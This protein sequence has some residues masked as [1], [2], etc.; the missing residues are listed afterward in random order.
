M[1]ENRFG[2]I[3]QNGACRVEGICRSLAAN[4]WVE[5]LA[6]LGYAAKGLVYLLVGALAGLAAWQVEGRPIGTRGALRTI[7]AQ[8]F[9]RY[10][11]ATVAVGIV[12]FILRRFLQTLVEEEGTAETAEEHQRRRKRVVQIARRIGYAMSGIFHIGIALTTVRLLLGWGVRGTDGTRE[13][14][15]WTSFLLAQPFGVWLVALA[16][17]IVIGVGVGQLYLS[18]TGN[19]RRDLKWAEMTRKPRQWALY[20]GR[21]GYAARGLVLLIVGGFLVQAAWTTDPR[22]ARGLGAALEALEG[23]PFGAWILAAVAAGLFAYGVYMMVAARY[24]R[25]LAADFADSTDTPH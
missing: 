13:V 24:L 22:Q 25:L 4:R 7:V 9:G 3:A 6:K 17:L 19:F 2:A 14:Q 20:S 15:D 8:P 5:R 16:G 23:Q 10:L 21:V 12:G 18:Y 11:M 1:S